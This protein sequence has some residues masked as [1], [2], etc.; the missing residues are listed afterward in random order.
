[1]QGCVETPPPTPRTPPET[2]TSSCGPGMRQ[3][4]GKSPAE[5]LAP[6]SLEFSAPQ[7]GDNIS[8][9]PAMELAWV[10]VLPN[11]PHK[12]S[13]LNRRTLPPQK[14]KGCCWGKSFS[15]TGG[16]LDK[17][18]SSTSLRP[19]G[20]LRVWPPYPPTHSLCPVLQPPAQPCPPHSTQVIQP[21][22]K[23]Y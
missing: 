7:P 11:S 16:C 15:P 20:D 13:T 9:P 10:F 2:S 22:H 14:A 21:S 1:M 4:R 8:H 19:Q 12:A 18:G 23:P 3:V 6:S 17:L 5:G